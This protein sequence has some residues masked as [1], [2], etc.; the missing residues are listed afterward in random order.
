MK[1]ATGLPHNAFD[2]KTSKLVCEFN[3]QHQIMTP[4]PELYQ[5]KGEPRK[6]RP[7]PFEAD[8]VDAMAMSANG[9]QPST[10]QDSEEV[11]KKAQPTGSKR[12]SSNDA[13][14]SS[15]KR[16][17]YEEES[18][19]E[20]PT[21]PTLIRTVLYGA[22]HLA[23][24]KHSASAMEIVIIDSVAYIW[25]Y[26]RQGAIQSY[27]LDFIEDLPHFMVLLL[28][29]QQ[30][31]PEGLGILNTLD[32]SLHIPGPHGELH[33]KMGNRL[34]RSWCIHGRA[35]A[36]FDIVEQTLPPAIPAHLVNLIRTDGLL[37]KLMW[38]ESN[39]VQEGMIIEEIYKR[40]AEKMTE[41][42]RAAV[43]GHIPDL[44]AWKLFDEL[45]TKT[46]RNDLGIGADDISGRVLSLSVFRRLRPITELEGDDFLRAWWDCVLCHLALWKVG[47]RHRDISVGNLMYYKYEGRVMGVLIDFDLSS[48][49]KEDEENDPTGTDCRG[50]LQFM[51]TDLLP[52]EYAPR[53]REHLYQ[54][55]FES[56]F[57]VLTWVAHRYQGGKEIQN[58]P[59]ND[60][61]PHFRESKISF[62]MDVVT[63]RRLP[64]PTSSFKDVWL[65]VGKVL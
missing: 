22:E 49:L 8:V 52:G 15:P 31:P 28:I 59:F 50:T 36:I 16:P 14:G 10:S 17:K 5:P 7:V 37:A 23:H 4:I 11:S 64:P 54:H 44:I 60:W 27:G 55:D 47:V 33:F 18:D 40:M 1:T 34:L 35:T 56:F 46:I 51:A 58:P 53:E 48:L 19:E 30:L 29:L 13:E 45:S 63:K 25:W 61:W 65:N 21:E 39:R 42:D 32:S 26:D 9:P 20:S 6:I 38:V 3:I 2:W 24:R 57:W 62:L 43:E 41:E 12:P